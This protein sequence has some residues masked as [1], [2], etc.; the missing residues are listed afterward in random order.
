MQLVGAPPETAH[1]TATVQAIS[2]PHIK[3][4]L[5]LTDAAISTGEASQPESSGEHASQAKRE[6]VP[7]ITLPRQSSDVRHFAMGKPRVTSP[8]RFCFHKS[9]KLFSP[10][11]SDMGGSLVKLVYFSPDAEDE[12]A[13]SLRPSFIGGGRL[14]FRKF[15][16]SKI[17]QCVRFIEQKRL[18]LGAEGGKAV[19]KATGGGAFKCVRSPDFSIPARKT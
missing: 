4:V 2:K 8:T 19:V 6:A 16:A 9:L 7:S 1:L 14:H 3:N 18:H 12:A 10:T 13:D 11:T 15:E 17:E 5:D